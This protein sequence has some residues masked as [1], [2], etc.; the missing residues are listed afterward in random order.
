MTSNNAIILSSQICTG[1]T[2][3]FQNNVYLSDKI[4]TF[5]DYLRTDVPQQEMTALSV[6]FYKGPNTQ[7]DFWNEL[8]T[9]ALD[10]VFSLRDQRSE[11][12]RLI[13]ETLEYVKANLY[14]NPSL[15]TKYVNQGYAPGLKSLNIKTNNINLGDWKSKLLNSKTQSMTFTFTM[16]YKINIY[17]NQKYAVDNNKDFYSPNI[18]VY[19][20]MTGSDVDVIIKEGLKNDN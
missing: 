4:M 20:T 3:W 2:N 18:D 12:A 9:I 8:G 16:D 11:R 17:L 14:Y 6:Y 7:T 10:F 1:V 19:H 15:I 5:S 13:I